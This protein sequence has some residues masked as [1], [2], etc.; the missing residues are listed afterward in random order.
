MNGQMKP[1]SL[2]AIMAAAIAQ[3]PVIERWHFG[4]DGQLDCHEIEIS[5][6]TV[7]WHYATPQCW[8]PGCRSFTD[9]AIE[10]RRAWAVA[11]IGDGA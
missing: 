6:D 8:C 10:R 7:P 11:V 5:L 9:D 3:V 2:Y 4:D 1:V